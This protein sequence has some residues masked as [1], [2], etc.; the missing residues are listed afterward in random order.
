MTGSRCGYGEGCRPGSVFAITFN[1]A[2]D[3]KAFDSSRV[4]ITPALAATVGVEGNT[5]T[6]NGETKSDTRYVVTIPGSLRDEFGQTL[7]ATAV[8]TFDVG[9]ATPAI[10]SFSQSLTTTDP[11]ATHPAVAITLGRAREPAGRRVR[12]E[13]VAL[14]RL[15][16]RPLAVGE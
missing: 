3:A 15:P 2:L 16:E 14:A 7:G 6:V 5:I 11:S 12:R 4:K 10:L 8:E 1:N 9:E 13:S